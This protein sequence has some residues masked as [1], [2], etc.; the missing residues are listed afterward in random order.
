MKNFV[1]KF[2]LFA[3]TIPYY[4]F[5]VSYLFL[6]FFISLASYSYSVSYT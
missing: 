2:I 3:E 4:V 5:F 6:Q 1:W